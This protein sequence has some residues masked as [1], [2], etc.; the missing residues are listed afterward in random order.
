MMKVF[1]AQVEQT[2][3]QAKIKLRPVQAEAWEKLLGHAMTLL[4]FK[5][6]YI[7]NCWAGEMMD[8]GGV[9]VV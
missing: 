8:G 4:N 2:M 5:K 6:M 1:R 7:F 3:K 9:E